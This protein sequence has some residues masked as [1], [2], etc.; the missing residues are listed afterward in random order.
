M[1]RI[2]GN[3]EALPYGQLMAIY[4]E[5]NRTKGRQ[6]YHRLDSSAQLLLTEQS[7]YQYMAE[8]MRTDTVMVAL[9]EVEDTAV[10]ALRLERYKDGLLLAGL[11]TSP[12]QR[13]RGYASSLVR[14]V[15][16]AFSAL[17]IYSHVYLDNHVSVALHEKCGFRKTANCA[18]L[19]D[20]SISHL[21]V[22]YEFDAK[23][24]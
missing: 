16:E 8:G 3:A 10:S 24:C 13:G 22:T 23:D 15:L 12:D 20:G 7:F 18:E 5:S 17:R 21:A 1:L 6:D 4:E 9:W 19:L 11:E 14:A 2:I